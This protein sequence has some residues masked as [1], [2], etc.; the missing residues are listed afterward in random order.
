V[1]NS[2]NWP[3]SCGATLTGAC[4]EEWILSR[5]L[6]GPDPTPTWKVSLH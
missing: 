6:L 1:L 4:G 2:Y 3:S 5:A